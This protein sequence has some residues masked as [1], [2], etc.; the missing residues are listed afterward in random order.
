M[1]YYIDNKI[2]GNQCIKLLN[3]CINGSTN[4][5]KKEW[6]ELNWHNDIDWKNMNYK[7]ALNI[8]KK[9]GLDK[10]SV[11]T[12]ISKLNNNIHNK[13]V[14][15]SLK[16]TFQAIKNK[17]LKNNSMIGGNNDFIVLIKNLLLR[18]QELLKNKNKK[19][20][21]N[22]FNRINVLIKDKK[23]IDKKY[24]RLID[25]LNAFNNLLHEDKIL[26]PNNK[27]E[28]TLKDI[29]DFVDN[30][31]NISNNN[32]SND[33]FIL[34]I[35]NLLLSLNKL[36]KNKNKKFNY[37]DFNRINTLIKNKKLIDTKYDILTEYIGIFNNLLDEDK[38]LIPNNKTEI[39]LKDIE[40]LVNNNI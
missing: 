14:S 40:N 20:N 7:D 17:I 8:A 35:N 31:N 36:L 29:E 18:L 16:M 6:F 15:D 27:V 26:I 39:T 32:I 13:T 33:D 19:I 12:V 22:D 5:Y 25:Y 1:N 37:N 34:L 11:E 30:N 21:Y 28:L 2:N 3:E 23:L 38:I 10:N 9:L 4:T 24:N